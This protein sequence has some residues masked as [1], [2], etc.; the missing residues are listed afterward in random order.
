M[1]RI[2]RE[3][4]CKIWAWV[5]DRAWTRDRIARSRCLWCRRR[6]RDS[7][8]SHSSL[9]LLR[10]CGLMTSRSRVIRLGTLGIRRRRIG[11]W[12]MIDT[13]CQRWMRSTLSRSSGNWN[14]RLFSRSTSSRTGTTCD[15]IHSRIIPPYCV[16]IRARNV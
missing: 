2:L 11:W 4:R 7:A 10:M 6:R 12:P 8:R 9:D 5:R 15:G 1:R 3:R 14:R 16:S 13:E